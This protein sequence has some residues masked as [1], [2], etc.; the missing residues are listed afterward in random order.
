MREN[1]EIIKRIMLVKPEAKR[2]KATPR[3]RWMDG[4]EKDLRNLGVVN[5]KTKAQDRHGWSK[6][7]KQAKIHKGLYV[8]PI[9]I[10]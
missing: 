10:I 1:E 6:F 4:V 8:V 2:K 3:M 9:I 7:L 5:W